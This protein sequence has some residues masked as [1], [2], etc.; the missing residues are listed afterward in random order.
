MKL[1]LCALMAGGLVAAVGGV[2]K[3]INI[4]FIAAQDDKNFFIANLVIWAY[5]ELWLILILGC[6]PPLRPLFSNL[7]YRLH[8]SYKNSY[9]NSYKRSEY[10]N[11]TSSGGDDEHNLT[12]MT[13]YPAT[14]TASAHKASNM[15]GDTDSERKILPPPATF[16]GDGILRTTAVHV[17][18]ERPGMPPKEV[19]EES[20]G[21]F[22]D[23]P[24]P[25]KA[26]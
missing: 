21:D 9:K 26:I 24:T 12:S 22:L 25:G 5:T 7:F 17:Q 14:H 15:F 8:S 1:G 11:Q 10:F 23:L 16:D 18:A 19:S 3:T 20:S 2:M 13:P 6:L 4:K